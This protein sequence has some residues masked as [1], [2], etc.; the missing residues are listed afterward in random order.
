MRHGVTDGCKLRLIVHHGGQGMIPLLAC[1]Y[2]K[3]RSLSD[4][5]VQTFVDHCK[6]DERL[7]VLIKKFEV[8]IDNYKAA[9]Q[10]SLSFSGLQVG[11]LSQEAAY[12]KIC[13]DFTQCQTPADF[14]IWVTQF[15]QDIAGSPNFLDWGNDY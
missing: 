3:W 7:A 8:R 15:N 13:G 4:I 12:H 2:Y 14:S 9:Y 6:E 10:W 5:E 11:S 1:Y